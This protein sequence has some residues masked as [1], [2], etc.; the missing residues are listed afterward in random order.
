MPNFSL[1]FKKKKILFFGLLF[2]AVTILAVPQ[3]AN[4]ASLFSAAKD[5]VTGL[6]NS[7]LNAV[8]YA[9]L[10]IPLFLT[11]ICADIAGTLLVWAIDLSKTISYTNSPGV[12]IG[13]PIV[14]DL[15]NM[16]IVLGFVVIGIATA[17]RIREWEAKQL[18]AKL[19]IVALL[20]NF[21][22]L[23]CGIFI[24]GTNILM[25]F[26]FSKIG[27]A[28]F[29]YKSIENSWNVL[30]GPAFSSTWFV[31]GVELVAMMFFNFIAFFIYLLYILL[32]LGRIIA[33]WMLVILSPLAFVCYVFPATKPVWSQWWKNFWQWC[34]IGI[35]AGL[36]YFIASQMI[37]KTITTPAASIGT[38]TILNGDAAKLIS[39]SI[40]LLLP[41]LF[42]IV[43]FLVSLQFSAMGA[44]VIMNFANKY[45]GKALSGGLGALSKTSGK[46][47]SAYKNSAL[48]KYAD[49][50]Q[51]K[52][53]FGNKIGGWVLGAPGKG[54]A[55]VANSP[56]RYQ[57]TKSMFGRGLERMGGMPTGTMGVAAI[58]DVEEAA[59]G[60]KFEYD[61]AKLSNDSG[62]I[63]R[64]R[65]DARTGQG[66]KG[67]AAYKVIS[68]AKDLADTF[69]DSHGDVDFGAIH[70][71][72]RFAEINGAQGVVAGNEKLNPE[73]RRYNEYM[74][75]EKTK[76]MPAASRAEIENAVVA[77]G[78]RK[79]TSPEIQ[80]YHKSV[81]G[82]NEFR[83]N[84]QATRV[85]SAARSG[86]GMSSEG[87][88]EIKK[89]I[90]K[91]KND[92]ASEL[93]LPIGASVSATKTAMKS[94]TA[95]TQKKVREIADKI[96]TFKNL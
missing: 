82:S 33:L 77:D 46:L 62:T 28:A 88:E 15:A 59:K 49:A 55:F 83:V 96:N 23:I 68:D 8:I 74:I 11:A 7:V 17:L 30:T 44:G 61:R 27:N 20:V 43:G 16:M 32:I 52:K 24:D 35:P 3:V 94:A 45:K 38:D 29:A 4:A 25:N 40:S 80:N 58:K 39:G 71:R 2:L 84:V 87:I 63:D 91:L 56:N 93:K 42:L 36:F 79:A 54:A 72:G 90:P 89:L 6:G 69:K 31:F 14:R 76:S 70:S 64:I 9:A 5:L 47:G 75:G 95:D 57:Q 78:F 86:N 37:S 51:A 18:L 53:G 67:A 50:M 22:L 65:N 10:A 60:I 26:F 48:G 81:L 73:L 21:S 92:I 85:E 66:M 34:I 13:W 19:I 41:G 12:Q 1:F